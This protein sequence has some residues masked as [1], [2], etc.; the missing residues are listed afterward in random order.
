MGTHPSFSLRWYRVCF[1]QIEVGV[2]PQGWSAL[3]AEVLIAFSDRIF[4]KTRRTLEVKVMFIRVLREAT[5][6][7]KKNMLYM[8]FR[9][10]G[11][12]LAAQYGRRTWPLRAR[13]R[14]YARLLYSRH[15][16]NHRLR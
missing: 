3:A 15:V 11:I 14:D 2:N 1:N 7:F 12:F 16:R 10:I 6:L 9:S 8:T 5:A 4:H 13:V